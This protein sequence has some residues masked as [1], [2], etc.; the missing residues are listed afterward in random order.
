MLESISWQDFFT[1]LAILVGT[2]YLVTSLLLYNKELVSLVRKKSL[3]TTQQELPIKNLS[4]ANQNLMG[5]IRY[6]SPMTTKENIVESQELAFK[7]DNREEEEVITKTNSTEALLVGT[8]A[9]LLQELKTLINI[10]SHNTM[11]ESSPLFR[12]ILTNYPQLVGSHYQ[13][14]ISLFIY[15][16]TKEQCEFTLELDQIKSW[17]PS[18]N[19]SN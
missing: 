10:V 1:T 5:E 13:E 12:A 8:I 14:A 3:P 16:T 9:D 17:W 19:T 7:S 6:N 4:G 11:E 2:Y 18:T 15:A